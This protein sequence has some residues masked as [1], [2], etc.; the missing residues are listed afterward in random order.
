MP[1]LY[2]GQWPRGRAWRERPPSKEI[3]RR[4][5]NGY[6]PLKRKK[7]P[8]PVKGMN[9]NRGLSRTILPLNS[10][11]FQECLSSGHDTYI[12]S[13]RFSGI[14]LIFLDFTVNLSFTTTPI[15]S[16]DHYFSFSQ[17]ER[18]R[19][20]ALNHCYRSLIFDRGLDEWRL[21]IHRESQRGSWGGESNS[22]MALGKG[23]MRSLAFFCVTMP[24]AR[25]ESNPSSLDS[26]LSRCIRGGLV[27][28]FERNS[29]SS[30]DCNW[31]S[32]CLLD[33]GRSASKRQTRRCVSSISLIE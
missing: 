10:R 20:V 33:L 22:L 25:G 26:T 21:S 30:G 19:F 16:P 11:F 2:S 32:W 6:R 14:F 17:D 4:K 8:V 7:R 3:W 29:P 24:R 12:E 1:R 9:I 27:C 18:W 31:S 15:L 13:L 5:E 23:G 28:S